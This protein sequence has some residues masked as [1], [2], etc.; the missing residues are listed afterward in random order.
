MILLVFGMVSIAFVTQMPDEKPRHNVKRVIR[1]VEIQHPSVDPPEPEPES[2]PVLNA[3]QV[4]ETNV[5]MEPNK[6]NKALVFTTKNRYGYVRLLAESLEWMKAY[7]HAHIHVFDDGS[8][9]FTIEELKDWF[10]YAHIHESDHRDPDMSTRH[11]FE[12][13]ENESEDDIL[14]NIDSDTMLHPD[15]NKFIDTHI[16]RSGVL[17]LYHSGA[18]YHRSVNCDDVSCEK[19]STGAMGIVMSRPILVDMLH[20]M[21]NAKHKAAAFDWGFVDYFKKK[22]I[23]IIVPKNS[24]ALHYG[25][26]GAHGSGNHVEVANTFDFTPFPEDIVTKAK[27]FLDNEKPDRPILI[28]SQLIVLVLSAR[29][30][31]S[32]RDAIRNTWAKGRSNVFF[33]VGKPCMYREV[34]REAWTCHPKPNVQK[35]KIIDVEVE[36]A[37][38]MIIVDVIDVY[39]NLASKLHAAYY[40]VL[41]HTDAQYILKTDDDTFVRV[42]LLHKWL[43]SRSTLPYEMIAADFEKN[44]KVNR[45]GKWAELSFSENVYPLFPSGSGHVVNRAVLEYMHAHDTTWKSYQGEDTSMGIWIE[46]VKKYI[47]ITLTSSSKFTSHRGDCHDTTKLVIGHNI[48]P[49]KMREC[50]DKDSNTDN[51]DGM[52]QPLSQDKDMNQLT[53]VCV[54]KPTGKMWKAFE[55]MVRILEKIQADYSISHGTVLFWYRDCS[56]GSSD[57]DMRID[58]TWFQ[59]HQRELHDELR[60]SGWRMERS[61]GSISDVGYEEAWL[62]NGVKCDL[63]STKPAERFHISGLT[64][65]GVTY[66]CKN[67]F[68]EIEEHTWGDVTFKVPVPIERYLE[69]MY[70]NWN[71][72]H[73]L[74]YKWDVEPFKTDRELCSKS[75]TFDDIQNNHPKLFLC[76]YKLG[77]LSFIYPNRK[78]KTYSKEQTSTVGDAMLHGLFGPPCDISTFKGKIIHINGESSSWGNVPENTFGSGGKTFYY[79]QAVLQRIPDGHNLITHRPKNT[80]KKFMYYANSNCVPYRDDAFD[81]I[82]TINHV[83]A[84][85]ACKNNVKG[86]PRSNWVN[87]WKTLS[88]YRFGLCMENTKA[89]GYIT[90]KILMAFLAGVIPVYYGTEEIF[91]IF[92]RKAFIYYD[93]KNPEEAITQIKY[94]EDNPDEYEKM[95]NEPILNDGSY[96]KYFSKEAITKTLTEG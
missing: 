91:D 88:D 86:L 68:N 76:G 36:D 90:E 52:K 42:G 71:E 45:Q 59:E 17:S 11:A 55:S 56:L 7:E 93:V 28:K 5:V 96:E 47:E 40:W 80:K 3:E 35:M 38:D 89:P 83:E 21:H 27:A 20:N 87:N 61:F 64:I 65:N 78:V 94:L 14:I 8:T 84:V 43:Q 58:L 81:K 49:K 23:K 34:D 53:N 1:G 85:G 25:M 46:N 26:Y 29:E 32:I 39:R 82:S 13:F 63:F 50:W 44:S 77:Y 37:S 75:E 2:E 10:P 16:D 18:K 67:F 51:P 70:G 72:K 73:I 48:T 30:H 92:N 4:A 31:R 57:I 69:K 60:K 24:L 19:K 54:N 95:L 66:P 9:D 15:W 12:W 33:V 79:V 74:G 22:G 62:L 6:I 41:E